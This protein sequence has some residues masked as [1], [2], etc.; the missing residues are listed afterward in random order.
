MGDETALLIIDVQ[1]G[2]FSDFGPVYQSRGILSRIKNLITRARSS[3]TPVI[4]IQHCSAPGGALEHGTP[5]WRIHPA[6]TPHPGEP[7]IQK[8]T[9]DCFQGTALQQKLKSL[10]VKK[11]V[12]AGL[13]TE[14][15]VDTACRRAFS[16]GYKVVLAA[17]AH[18]TFDS[19]M[20]CAADIVKHHN[21]LLGTWFVELKK[22]GRIEFETSKR[23]KLRVRKS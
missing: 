21:N 14:F 15:C 8:R 6:I 10:G 18:S 3:S 5:G 9:P 12:I 19:E 2:I 20:L 1:S 11:V 13:Q 4:Y 16:L 17:D 22:A 23:S 7:V